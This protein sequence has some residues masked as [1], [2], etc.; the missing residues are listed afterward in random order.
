VF[1]R[2]HRNWL[3]NVTH[4]KELERD[5]ASSPTSLRAGSNLAN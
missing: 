2:V 5:S 3:V 1:T 4:V